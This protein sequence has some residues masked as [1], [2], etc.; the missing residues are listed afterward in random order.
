MPHRNFCV[1]VTTH[2]HSSDLDCVT[3]VKKK[4]KKNHR[5]NIFTQ[6]KFILKCLLKTWSLVRS[7][8]RR[9]CSSSNSGIFSAFSVTVRAIN[10]ALGS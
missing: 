4:K 9:V 7:E 6:G 2:A 3:M 8:S 5:G 1:T 10:Q